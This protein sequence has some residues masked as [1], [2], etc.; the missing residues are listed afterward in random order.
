MR[1]MLLRP[2]ELGTGMYDS[3]TERTSWCFGARSGERPDRQA[4][5]DLWPGE[6]RQFV[7]GDPVAPGAQS[8]EPT[9]RSSASA[10][11]GARAPCGLSRRAHSGC[12]SVVDQ[13]PSRMALSPMRSVTNDSGTVT[14]R[15]T[16]SLP[17]ARPHQAAAGDDQHQGQAGEQPA[18]ARPNCS[19]LW[20]TVPTPSSAIRPCAVPVHACSRAAAS[21]G[22]ARSKSVQ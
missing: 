8:T 22:F 17:A 20:V 19:A 13:T 2:L 9:V 10:S 11:L 12:R 7:V 3:A 5:L 18:S 14:G 4:D 16:S 15:T 21:I 1:R 6:R